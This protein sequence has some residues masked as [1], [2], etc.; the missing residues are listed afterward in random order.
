LIGSAAIRKSFDEV[1]QYELRG[2]KVI[3]LGDV[4]AR[5]CERQNIRHIAVCHPSRR[6][7]TN[8]ENAIEI[9]DAIEVL[10]FGGGCAEAR[11]QGGGKFA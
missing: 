10:G 6:G 1:T 3:A 9:S 2:R 5:E 4:A 8:E 7:H 11:G